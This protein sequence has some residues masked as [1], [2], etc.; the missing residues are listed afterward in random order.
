M[1]EIARQFGFGKGQPCGEFGTADLI[2]QSFI[3]DKRRR[4]ETWSHVTR[5]LDG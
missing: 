2:K 3:L 4:P 1:D 5:L